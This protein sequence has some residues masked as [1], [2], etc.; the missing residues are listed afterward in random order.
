[1]SSGNSGIFLRA[2]CFLETADIQ[3]RWIMIIMVGLLQGWSQAQFLCSSSL[4][5]RRISFNRP[6]RQLVHFTEGLMHL[7]HPLKLNINTVRDPFEIQHGWKDYSQWNGRLF[8]GKHFGR[9]PGGYRMFSTID[10]SVRHQLGDPPL[11]SWKAVPTLHLTSPEHFRNLNRNETSKH[12][13][14]QEESYFRHP[15]RSF[16]TFLL[17]LVATKPYV[18]T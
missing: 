14:N 11:L 1:M 5:E 9:G 10:L 16:N 2:L 17:C 12:G 6:G 13:K 7:I 18:I 15:N 4:S 8:S 3:D